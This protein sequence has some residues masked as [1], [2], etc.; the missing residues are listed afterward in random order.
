M[1]TKFEVETTF[2]VYIPLDSKFKV[3]TTEQ[4]FSR[5]YL[6]IFFEFFIRRRLKIEQR[7]GRVIAEEDGIGKRM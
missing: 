2:K 4:I 1:T 6:V 7:Q 5:K 3:K